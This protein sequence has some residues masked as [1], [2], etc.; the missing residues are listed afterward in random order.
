MR[1][2]ELGVWTT[3]GGPAVIAFELLFVFFILSPRTRPWAAAAG[4]AFHGAVLIATGINF[5]TLLVCYTVFVDTSRSR[6]T[7]PE[8]HWAPAAPM[9][10]EGSRRLSIG[11]VVASLLAGLTLVDSWPFA[12][13]PTFAGIA[14]PNAWTV[15]MVGMTEE[16]QSVSLRPWRSEA[17]RSRFGNSRV[18]GLVSQV[19]WTQDPERRKAKAVA[20]AAVAS[21]HEPALAKVSELQIFRELVAV[22]PA[23]WSDPPLRREFLGV[24]RQAGG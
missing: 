12:V 15:T 22:D 5:W 10:T 3:L 16:G 14:E 1:F 19:A 4:I 6:G 21:A 24:W 11:L 23:R 9:P 13:Y 17:L 7:K 2:D 20:L 18:G 8:D